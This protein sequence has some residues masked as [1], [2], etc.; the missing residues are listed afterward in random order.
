VSECTHKCREG[1]KERENLKQTPCWARSPTRDSI[2]QLKSWPE[3]KS[4]VQHLTD[5][6]TQAPLHSF[7]FLYSITT[8]SFQGMCRVQFFAHTILISKCPVPSVAQ[9]WPIRVGCAVW[10]QKGQPTPTSWTSAGASCPS[11]VLSPIAGHL[12]CSHSFLGCRKPLW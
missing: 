1:Q 6:A 5:W 4:G 2:P 10:S 11:Y 12:H 8:Y 9:L 3:P 7:F